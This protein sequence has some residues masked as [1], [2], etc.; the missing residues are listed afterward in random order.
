MTGKTAHGEQSSQV[1]VA[2]SLHHLHQKRFRPHHVSRIAPYDLVRVGDLGDAPVNPIDLMDSLG[3]IEK[4]FG[5]VHAA[6]AV[7]LSAGGGSAPWIEQVID[8]PGRLGI[9]LPLRT[10]WGD[11]VSIGDRR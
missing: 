7:P 2:I 5:K 1:K 8:L 10:A 11:P 9:P 6:G 4:F 3:R